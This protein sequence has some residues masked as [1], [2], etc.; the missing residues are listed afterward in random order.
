MFVRVP[1]H[2]DEHERVTR[3]LADFFAPAKPDGSWPGQHLPS[4]WT[5]SRRP[6]AG[7]PRLSPAEPGADSARRAGRG[8]H[9]AAGVAGGAAATGRGNRPGWLRAP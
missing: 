9:G 4:R 1:L 7:W 2:H 6:N 8:Q 5:S 3:L